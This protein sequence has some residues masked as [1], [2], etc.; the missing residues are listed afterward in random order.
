VTN[1]QISSFAAGNV[2]GSVSIVSGNA[3]I[4]GATVAYVGVVS[5]SVTADGAGNFTLLELPDGDYT[6]T[7][8]K[9]GYTFSPASA[10]ETVS[11]ADI[12][13]VNFTA[14]QASNG[15]AWFLLDKVSFLEDIPRRRGH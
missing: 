7:P 14:T 3:G 11:G 1:A 10:N 15:G 2:S 6:I 4:A 5:G 8:S 13:G 12:T 9:T